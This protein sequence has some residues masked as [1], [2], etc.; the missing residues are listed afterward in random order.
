MDTSRT[1]E[2]ATPEGVAPLRAT[3][4]RGGVI[5]TAAGPPRTEADIVAMLADWAPKP[6]D[7][8]GMTVMPWGSCE[9]AS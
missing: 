1:Q 7:T 4:A 3:R 9:R 2:H 8:T 5:V 6:V